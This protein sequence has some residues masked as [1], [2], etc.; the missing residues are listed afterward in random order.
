MNEFLT[1]AL[2][3]PPTERL[4]AERGSVRVFIVSEPDPH[5]GLEASDAPQVAASVE[6]NVIDLA[7]VRS[8]GVGSEPGQV[9]LL[10]YLENAA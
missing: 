6:S 4:H 9:G 2:E 7:P 1:P 8:Q 5:T 3:Q 10:D